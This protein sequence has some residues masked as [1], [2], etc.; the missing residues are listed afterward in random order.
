MRNLLVIGDSPTLNT[1]FATVVKNLVPRW[2][3]Y[4]DRIDI[5]AIAHLGEP[6]DWP[7]RLY[8]AAIMDPHWH[9]GAQLSRLIT[10]LNHGDYTDVWIIQDHFLLAQHGLPRAI[11]EFREKRGIRFYYYFPVDAPLMKEWVEPMKA[12]DFPVAYCEYGVKEVRK[13]WPEFGGAHLPHGVSPEF[14][15]HPDEQ[16]AGLRERWGK[17]FFKDFDPDRDF[18]LVNV[19]THNKRKGLVQSLQVAAY[20][21]ASETPSGGK[22]RVLFHT[23]N[24]NAFDYTSL[25]EMAEQLGLVKGVSWAHTD[26][27][28]SGKAL[29]DAVGAPR[30]SAETMVDLYNVADAV[31]TTTLGEGWGLAI[32]EALACGCPVF[33]PRHTSCQCIAVEYSRRGDPYAGNMVHGIRTAGLVVALPMDTGRLRNPI[34]VVDAGVSIQQYAGSKILRTPLN[35]SQREWLSWDRIAAEWIRIF[36]MPAP[37]IPPA[38]GTEAAAPAEETAVAK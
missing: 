15:P 18:L 17:L 25:D 14:Q 5:W 37:E 20:L 1:G 19:S 22:Y 8:P 30:L 23:K 38:E 7:E 27:R 26:V 31:L 13:H 11:K 4:F 24:Q 32:T 3:D 34:D 9:S 21:E 12:V 10:L 2:R 6:T 29:W 16:R 35:E 36:D 28:L 33:M